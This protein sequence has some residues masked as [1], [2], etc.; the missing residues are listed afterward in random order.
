MFPRWPLLPQEPLAHLHKTLN[1]LWCSQHT[2]EQQVGGRSSFPFEEGE[3][4]PTSA[5]L[6]LSRPSHYQKPKIVAVTP[7]VDPY[8]NRLCLSISSSVAACN[9]KE[10]GKNCL[11]SRFPYQLPQGPEVSFDCPWTKHCSKSNSKII[12]HFWLNKNIYVQVWSGHQKVSHSYNPS[13]HINVW[14]YCLLSRKGLGYCYTIQWKYKR[15]F[16]HV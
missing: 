4:H 10:R 5:V 12:M 3:T 14:S 8:I 13:L 7:A 9:C 6:V 11:C 1:V 16:Y 15:G 2:S